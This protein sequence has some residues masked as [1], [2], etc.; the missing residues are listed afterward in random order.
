MVGYN[1]V[2]ELDIRELDRAGDVTDA[3]GL[4]GLKVRA[5][6]EL[7]VTSLRADPKIG[8]SGIQLDEDLCTA[9]VNT[10]NEDCS[11]ADAP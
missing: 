7:D 11:P 1:V 2:S 3:I 4:V 10:I 8:R 9:R 5:V 6:R